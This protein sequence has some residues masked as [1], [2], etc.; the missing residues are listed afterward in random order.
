MA[1]PVIGFVGL[2]EAGSRIAAGLRDAG[3]NGMAAYDIAPDRVRERAESAG[4]PL[5]ASN[6]ELATRCTVMF[7]VVTAASALDAARQNQPHLGAQHIYVDCNSVSPDTKREIGAVIQGTPA[8]FVEAAILAPVP[9]LQGQGVSM[10]VN[11]DAAAELAAQMK[12]LGFRMEA[13]SDPIG[14]AAAVKMCRSIVIKGLEA[15]LTECVLAASEFGAEERVFASIQQTYPGVEWKCL[16]DYVVNRLTVHGQRRAHEMEEVARMLRSAGIDPIM[17]EATVRRQAWS[18]NLKLASHF[19]PE[20]PATYAEV[21]E[22]LSQL[23]AI[24]RSTP[25]GSHTASDLEAGSAI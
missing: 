7:S 24:D 20:G 2:G 13:L 3:V 23:G 16:A 22:V 4:V 5:L 21:L 25:G 19:G 8:R 14:T 1:A 6:G 12:P 10:L 11:G 17:S 9:K 15:L 18:A